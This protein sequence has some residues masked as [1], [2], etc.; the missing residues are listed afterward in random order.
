MNFH[1]ESHPF[2]TG[3]IAYRGTERAYH[4]VSYLGLRGLFSDLRKA[5]I[6]TQI[7]LIIAIIPDKIPNGILRQH[8]LEALRNL[9]AG[10]PH[11]FG[12]S[13]G[14]DLIFENRRYPPKAI[15]GLAAARVN[16]V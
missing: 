4:S 1:N 8:I 9:D 2:L 7:V 13:T 12:L 5:Y 14:Y 11:K 6:A 3:D 10:V 15:I 16:G